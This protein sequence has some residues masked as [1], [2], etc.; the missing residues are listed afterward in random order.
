[1]Y[2]VAFESE[3]ANDDK[4]VILSVSEIS[5]EDADEQKVVESV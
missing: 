3:L 1:M 5:V 4:S 2:T